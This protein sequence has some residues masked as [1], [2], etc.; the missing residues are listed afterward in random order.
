MPRFE[1]TVEHGATTLKMGEQVDGLNG[2]D[3]EP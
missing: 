1:L 2:E 3:D